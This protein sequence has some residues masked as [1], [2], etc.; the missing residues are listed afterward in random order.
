MIT[1]VGSGLTGATAARILTDKGHKVVV[2]EERAH[3]GGNVYTPLMGGVPIHVYG[4]HIFHTSSQ[5]VWDFV[6]R[7]C[8]WQPYIYRPRAFTEGRF[9]S[10]PV[11]LLTFH[12]LDSRIT[13][14]AQAEAFLEGERALVRKWLKWEPK[15]LEEQW[16]SQMGIKIYEMFF[17]QYSLKQWGLSPREMLPTISGRVPV[18]TAFEENYFPRD[19]WQAQPIGGYSALISGLLSGVE[20]KLNTPWEK[21]RGERVIYTGKLDALFNYD[22]G[23]LPYR[24]L[25]FQH[26]IVDMAESQGSAVINYCDLSVPHTRT[27]EHWRFLGKEHDDGRVVISVETPAPYTDHRIPMYPHQ[28]AE[29][30]ALAGEYKKRLKELSWCVSGGRLAS[31]KYLNMD[32]AIAMGMRLAEQCIA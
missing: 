10:F 19:R 11:N 3:E 6:N 18:T 22:L 21:R 23:H 32:Q 31:Y 14:P 26:R 24:S 8:E 30:V 9:Y 15:N 4:P 16:K 2:L 17:M 25:D 28:T 27:I 7:F 5:M 20:V 13:T 1:I 29:A 12:Q